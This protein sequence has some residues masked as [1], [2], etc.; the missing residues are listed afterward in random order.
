MS[1]LKGL[2]SSVSNFAGPVAGLAGTAIGGPA[3]GAA[4][5]AIGGAIGAA[6]SGLGGP[7]GEEVGPAAQAER[8]GLDWSKIGSQVLEKG[9]ADLATLPGSLL[10]RYAHGRLDTH[11][12]QS[13]QKKL[14]PDANSLD[15]LGGGGGGTSGVP[16]ETVATLRNQKDIAKIHADA[17]VKN[18][19]RT[20]QA[21]E[22]N[23]DVQTQDMPS[24]ISLNEGRLREAN[25]NWKLLRQ[26]QRTEIVNTAIRRVQQ[27]YQAELS[28]AEISSLNHGNWLKTVASGGQEIKDQ[29]GGS[30]QYKAAVQYVADGIIEA[31]QSLGKDNSISPGKSGG[32]MSR[33]KK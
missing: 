11:T 20:A 17:S 1:A 24:K 27:K 7:N 26:R 14:Y 3:G 16:P 8:E 28:Q 31:V 33:N 10:S 4:G 19:E 6:G 29:I 15:L 5:S 23:T 22:R 9:A 30:E 2:M 25:A 13:R 12:Q 32:Q 18:T 21:S